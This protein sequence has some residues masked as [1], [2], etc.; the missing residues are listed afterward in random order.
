MPSRTTPIAVFLSLTLVQAFLI[1]C[2]DTCATCPEDLD[3]W[4][5]ASPAASGMDG[6]LLQE[7]T[8]EIGAGSLGPVSSLLIVRDGQLVYDEYFLGMDPERLHNCYSVTKSF[9]SA[10]IGIAK[11]QGALGDL[12]TPVL[13]LFPEYSSVEH[14]GDQKRAITLRHALQ[15]RS[16]FEWDEW[17]VNYAT[18]ENPLTALYFSD[19][20]IKYTL[21]LPMAGEPGTEFLYNTG[22]SVLLSGVIQ[23]STGLSAEAFAER[24]LFEP[25]GIEEWEWYTGPNGITDTGGGLLLRPR[26]MARFG[27]LFLHNGVWEPTGERLI[28]AAWVHES[29]QPYST[30]ESGGG[31]GY[32]WWVLAAEVGGAQLFFPYAVGWGGQ[33]IYVVPQL[34]LVVVMTAEGYSGEES[35]RGEILFDY[36]FPAAD[37]AWVGSLALSEEVEFRIRESSTPSLR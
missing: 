14:D 9:A 26:D 17:S 12:D 22:V 29:T 37:P 5:V 27:Y 33:R 35:F 24:N 19:D 11:D 8:E 4:P 28:P 10:L 7:L 1:A 32:Q 34:D 21:D 16:G 18:P 6:Q 31:Y 15:M 20:W 25:M 30:W 3:D 36:V 23:N 2:S 13:D